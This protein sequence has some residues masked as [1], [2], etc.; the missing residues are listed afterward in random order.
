MVSA[1]CPLLFPFAAKQNVTCESLF[2]FPQDCAVGFDQS[3]EVKV[4]SCSV[5]GRY[6]VPAP[7]LSQ[8]QTHKACLMGL[9][10]GFGVLQGGPQYTED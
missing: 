9:K 8:G 6:K 2:L 7:P 3:Q 1:R 10:L 5:V 4:R